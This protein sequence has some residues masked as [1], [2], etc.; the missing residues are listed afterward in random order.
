MPEAELNVMHAVQAMDARP[1]DTSLRVREEEKDLAKRMKTLFG[2]DYSGLDDRAAKEEEEAE[3]KEADEAYETVLEGQT[4]DTTEAPAKKAR[5]TKLAEEDAGPKKE[6]KNEEEQEGILSSDEEHKEVDL[7]TGKNNR[8]IKEKTVSQAEVKAFGQDGK[9]AAVEKGKEQIENQFKYTD[10]DLELYGARLQSKAERDKGRSFV[11]EEENTTYA[12]GKV[13][14][15][16]FSGT[17]YTKEDFE[18]LN[19][20]NLSLFGVPIDDS[21][22]QETK[23]TG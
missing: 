11:N 19:M 21:E 7:K 10:Q 9:R 1:E 15:C 4:S 3:E 16:N 13:G 5:R 17:Q 14:K 22:A 6:A 23:K 2:K 18:K 20:Q 8:F 12:T